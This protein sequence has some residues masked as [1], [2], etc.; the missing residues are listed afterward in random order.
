MGL[1][2]SFSQDDEERDSRSEQARSLMA[3]EE[4]LDFLVIRLVR[5]EKSYSSAP[6]FK[7][8]AT[9]PAYTRLSLFKRIKL[10]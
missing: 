6:F 2:P 1:R 4:M 7:S 10:G 8:N 5:H 3:F 9:R